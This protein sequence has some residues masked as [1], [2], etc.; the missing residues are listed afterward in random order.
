M[1][2][3]QGTIRI[4]IQP[5]RALHIMEAMRVERNLETVSLIP[6]RIGVGDNAL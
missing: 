5:D 6:H 4:F 1:E 3:G 2:H